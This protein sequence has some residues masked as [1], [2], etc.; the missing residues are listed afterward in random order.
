[1]RFVLAIDASSWT[2]G[3]MPN[4]TKPLSGRT[5]RPRRRPDDA[6]DHPLGRVSVTYVSR[7]RGRARASAESDGVERASSARR[8]L[9]AAARAQRFQAKLTVWHEAWRHGQRAGTVREQEHRL[10]PG[11]DAGVELDDVPLPPPDDHRPQRA[12]LPVEH[13]RVVDD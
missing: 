1:M 7:R 10:V 3:R 8:R 13:R 4:E 2:A 12:T 11:P 5:A 6:A 9:R